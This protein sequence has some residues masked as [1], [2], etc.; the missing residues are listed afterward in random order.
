[1]VAKILADP[2]YGTPACTDV[3]CGASPHPS[4]AVEG[5]AHKGANDALAGRVT[6]PLM[7]LPA[8]NDSDDYRP[9]GAIWEALTAG[10]PDSQLVDEFQEMIHGWTT[11]GDLADP[12]VD[13]DVKKAINHI[14][15]FFNKH[16][17]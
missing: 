13:R 11:R 12:A 4:L 3:V 7:L 9:G 8:G 14:V 1:M 10:S 6:K 17:K 2:E 16:A 15:G 5:W